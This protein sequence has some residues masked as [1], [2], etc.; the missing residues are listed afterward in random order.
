MTRIQPINEI[1]ADAETTELLGLVK[2]KMGSVPNLIS[3]M[4]NSLSVIKAYLGFNQALSTGT[5][6]PRLRE[7][8]ALLVSE[9]NNC[10]YCLAAHTVIGMGTGLSKQETMDARRGTS[11]SDKERVA[12]EF[13]R[14]IVLNHGIVTD[15][16]IMQIRQAG[17]SDGEIAEIVAN[18][19]LNI[20]TNYFNLVAETEV[21]FEAAPG[22][23]VS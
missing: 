10:E 19:A 13:T 7:Q 15:N 17:Y 11:R 20:F 14:Q 23:S 1:T 22:I 2:K 4:A 6:S 12:L 8:I 3:T 9:T 5:L 16:D 21:D 18:I